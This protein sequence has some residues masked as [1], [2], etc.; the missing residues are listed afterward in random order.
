MKTF[1]LLSIVCE[2]IEIIHLRKVFGA[3][4][5]PNGIHLNAKVPYGH[6]KVVFSYSSRVVARVSI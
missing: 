6:L 1:R 3:L 4:H 2:K 5:S